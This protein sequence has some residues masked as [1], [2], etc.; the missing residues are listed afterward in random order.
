MDALK[1]RMPHNFCHLTPQKCS[2]GFFATTFQQKCK[3]LK[4][5]QQ[6]SLKNRWT[7]GVA[8]LFWQHLWG[9]MKKTFRNIRPKTS[10]M[11]QKMQPRFFL[12]HVSAKW[13]KMKGHKQN[14]IKKS[15]KW[16][17]RFFGANLWGK[18]EKHVRK[19][20]NMLKKSSPIAFVWN[21]VQKNEEKSTN[22]WESDW[23]MLCSF[24]FLPNPLLVNLYVI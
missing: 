11:D 14:K 21:F 16:C 9:K 10:I 8:A 23:S 1:H 4:G 2:R 24:I 22:I 19:R 15:T 6:K 13:R 17:N 20:M 18:I 5:Q 3:K 7:N 12:Y